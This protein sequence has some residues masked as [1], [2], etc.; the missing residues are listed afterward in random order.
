[1]RGGKRFIWRD[2]TQWR[3]RR[4]FQSDSAQTQK[5]QI[6][7]KLWKRENLLYVLCPI[8]FS[9]WIGVTVFFSAHLLLGWSKKKKLHSAPAANCSLLHAHSPR[10]L[11]INYPLPFHLS[12]RPTQLSTPQKT[13][14]GVEDF[15]DTSESLKIQLLQNIIFVKSNFTYL[16][17]L[18]LQWREWL[19]DIYS[20]KLRITIWK[21]AK[22]N[23]SVNF[24][25]QAY[26]LQKDHYF[27]FCS[28]LHFAILHR[29]FWY[30]ILL[31]RKTDH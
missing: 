9:A 2:L 22:T 23:K 14:Q 1:M 21:K 25:L 8:K 4:D 19:L 29:I 31:V 28:F 18:L 5:Q 17:E 13:A 16:N 7:I 30:V 20:I 26:I 15:F 12:M 24:N 10:K 6:Y 11:F 3:R 27:L